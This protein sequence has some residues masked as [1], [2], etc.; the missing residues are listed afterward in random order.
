MSHRRSDD[1]CFPIVVTFGRDCTPRLSSGFKSLSFQLQDPGK[2]HDRR[3]P[4]STH[5]AAYSRGLQEARA[6][7]AWSL[8]AAYT[9]RKWLFS[10]LVC[11]VTAFI[12]LLLRSLAQDG[13][14]FSRAAALGAPLVFTADVLSSPVHFNVPQDNNRFIPRVVHQ[15]L[16]SQDAVPA[17]LAARRRSWSRFNP[18][19]EIQIWD[20]ALSR[21]FVRTNYPEYVV[22][23]N[24]LPRAS[25]RAHFFRYLVVLHFGGAFA[26]ADTECTEPL[27][28]TI[29]PIDHLVVGWDA[30]VADEALLAPGQARLR[31][32]RDGACSGRLCLPP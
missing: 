7:V 2:G 23:Y 4:Y 6:W 17:E 20:D 10:V 5:L 28:T 8:Q 9:Y 30:D 12:L 1:Q 27:D 22:A 32:V 11:G 31:Q 18:G 24:G 19:W 16:S 13:G 21:E 3:S 26:D 15:T 14:L 29:R 25:E